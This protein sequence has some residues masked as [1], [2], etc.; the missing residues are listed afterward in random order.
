MGGLEF[1][2]VEYTEEKHNSCQ[3]ITTILHSNPEDAL[4][5]LTKLGDL[6]MYISATPKLPCLEGT[7][8]HPSSEYLSFGCSSD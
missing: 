3:L 4:L 1:S 7:C 5:S 8:A 6:C 2:W